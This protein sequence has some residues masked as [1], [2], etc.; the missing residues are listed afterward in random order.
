VEVFHL[1]D[2]YG[3]SYFPAQVERVIHNSYYL[4]K[5]ESSYA[6]PNS[7]LTEILEPQYLRPALDCIPI[8]DRFMAGSHVEVF[9]KGGWSP[10]LV[11][12]GL[13]GSNY[14]VTVESKGEPMTMHFNISSLRL[15]LGW[16]GRRWSKWCSP[17]VYP[18]FLLS[19]ST[20]SHRTLFLLHILSCLFLFV[21]SRYLFLFLIML[22]LFLLT[23][24]IFSIKSF[25]LFLSFY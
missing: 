1:R 23:I 11:L 9:H 17:K 14:A 21:S 2:D 25:F 19:R 12:S 10:G 7:Y 13:S 20:I 8:I 22:I 24:C 4:V 15:R 5:Y 3:P 18:L 6:R 16:N